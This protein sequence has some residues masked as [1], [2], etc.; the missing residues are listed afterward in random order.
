M[1]IKDIFEAIVQRQEDD[2]AYVENFEQSLTLFEG[3]TVSKELPQDAKD[4]MHVQAKKNIMRA[5]YEEPIHDLEVFRK[6]F[7]EHLSYGDATPWTDA[8]LLEELDKVLK[9]MRGQI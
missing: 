4:F 7:Q 8:Y 9:K 6:M 2:R 1:N 3:Y 5:I